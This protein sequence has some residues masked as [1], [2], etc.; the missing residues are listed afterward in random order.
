MV[1]AMTP[2]QVIGV[3]IKTK[4]FKTLWVS[5]ATGN[6]T[7]AGLLAVWCLYVIQSG[8]RNKMEV[9]QGPHS[10]QHKSMMCNF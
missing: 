7:N 8:L 4:E 5:K 6:A 10:D 3:P 2:L 9:F 1:A